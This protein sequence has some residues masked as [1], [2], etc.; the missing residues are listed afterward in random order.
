[1][2]KHYFAAAAA[3]A[4]IGSLATGQGISNTKYRHQQ[5]IAQLREQLQ[6]L[7]NKTKRLE[8]KL[9]EEEDICLQLPRH[10]SHVVDNVQI[11]YARMQE[12]VT[13]DTATCKP[14]QE[15]IEVL[16]WHTIIIYNEKTQQ[17]GLG[18]LLNAQGHAI[19]PAHIVTDQYGS[20][21]AQRAVVVTTQTEVIQEEG[22]EGVATRVNQIHDIEQVLAT[23]WAT[24]IALIR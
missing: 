9:W 12:I 17:T 2:K 10:P 21:N 13:K 4:L 24:G 15:L 3:L 5:E 6:Q 7:S 23:D 19:V 18:I 11:E 1:M 20:Y 8:E 16:D 22:G 14:P